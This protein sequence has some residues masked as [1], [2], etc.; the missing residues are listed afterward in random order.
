MG[1]APRF[2]VIMPVY[3]VGAYLDESVG[4][5]L[6][7]TYG[8]YEVILVDD[9]STDGSGEKCDVYAAEHPNFHVIHQE[10]RGLLLARR[11]GFG[12]ACGEYLVSLDSDDMLRA[13]AL[14]VVADAI[15]KYHP[16]IVTFAFS[17]EK[18]FA[19][20][21]PSRLPVE[22][23]YY[24]GSGYDLFR[25]IVCGG[26]HVNIWSKVFRREIVDVGRDYSP[27]IGMTHAED[28]FQILAPT[29]RGHSFAY[30]PEALYFYRPN[31]KSST[32]R[33]RPR[34][35]DDLIVAL[36]ALQEYALSWGGAC[37]RLAKKSCVLQCSYL[38]HILLLDSSARPLWR[39]EFDRLCSYAERS[40]LFG[41][42]IRELRAD[43]RCEAWAMR[44]GSLGAAC[45]FVR[46]HTL[47][48]AARRR[49]AA[50]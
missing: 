15:D 1:T 35:L 9:G 27:Y 36:D 26:H 21:G 40:G 23:G 49:L 45:F 24:E 6:A 43:K 33:F 47:L 4:S 34:Q 11:A 14:A 31:E 13:D 17:R 37:R 44:R 2:S 7:Q 28:L 48:K 41:D 12:K 10:N 8:D 32:A 5:V 22:A 18:S 29:D 30:C 19:L 38:L 25:R 42:W 3:N 46:C 39:K 16:D 50:R 20:Y